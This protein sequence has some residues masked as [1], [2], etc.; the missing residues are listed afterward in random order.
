MALGTHGFWVHLM[1]QTA[2]GQP[3]D[4][5]AARNGKTYLIDCKVCSHDYFRLDRV[6]ENQHLAMMKWSETGNKFGWFALKLSNG[7]VYMVSEKSIR[8][9]EADG[10]HTLTKNLILTY[11]FSLDEWVEIY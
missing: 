6:E 4:I 8:C 5:I 3:A 7:D 10:L 11:G 2:A 1:A 9:V